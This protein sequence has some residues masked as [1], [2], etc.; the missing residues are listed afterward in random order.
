MQTLPVSGVIVVYTPQD[1][2]A[3]IVKKAVRMAQK[4]D[5][6]IIGVVENMS[7]LYVEEIDKKIELFGKSQGD[8]MAKAANAPLLGQLPIDPN[9]AKLCDAGAIEGYDSE[10]INSVG[11][12]IIKATAK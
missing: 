7:Y 10:F 3:M 8:E 1:L 12:A 6:P 5:K 11:K 4:M 2:T 9:L